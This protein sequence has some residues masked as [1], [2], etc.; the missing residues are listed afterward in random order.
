MACFFGWRYTEDFD[1]WVRDPRALRRVWAYNSPVHSEGKGYRLIYNGRF[2]PMIG[3]TTLMGSGMI[4]TDPAAARIRKQQ[5]KDRW[6]HNKA[7]YGTG[8]G[9]S[10][11]G[12]G[13]KKQ[14]QRPRKKTTATSKLL[15]T[16][17]LRFLT[18]QARGSLVHRQMVDVLFCTS[19]EEF[20][21]RPGNQM[22]LHPYV[23][24]LI[25]LMLERH[26]RPLKAEYR[27][28]SFELGCA[29]QVDV[30]G[31]D[32]DGCITFVEIKTGYSEGAFD[33]ERG[34]DIWIIPGLDA[35]RDSFP[36]TDRNKAIV[37]LVLGAEMCIRELGLDRQFVRYML[38]RI[39]D[40]GSQVIQLSPEFA[41]D[42]VEIVYDYFNCGRS[43]K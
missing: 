15:E 30:V 31:V 22:G 23:P 4:A 21:H 6:Y 16:S 3:L 37:Q 40:M 28:H 9:R 5:R 18:G 12:T 10:T 35:K 38:L 41:L 36:C 7:I 24:R 33:K 14:Q 20:H 19:M 1:R 27:I 39:D 17:P 43:M 8:H 34:G 11:D 2:L 25:A 26:V 13:L 32:R 29:T 42:I